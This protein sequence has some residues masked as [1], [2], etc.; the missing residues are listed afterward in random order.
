MVLVINVTTWSFKSIF[1]N[2]LNP[3]RQFFFLEKNVN[4][5]YVDVDR[6]NTGKWWMMA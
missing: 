6:E 2:Q 4:S 1:V 5:S 3:G